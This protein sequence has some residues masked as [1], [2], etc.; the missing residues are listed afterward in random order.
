MRPVF[1]YPHATIVDCG[2]SRTSVAVFSRSRN[3]RLRLE[4]HATFAFSG[5]AGQEGNWL[6]HTS[7]ALVA[8][9]ARVN[10]VG[11][12]VVVLPPHLT[13]M[14][15]LSTPRVEK[16]KREKIISFEGQ[17]SIPYPLTD[18]VWD[19]MISGENPLGFNILLCA[20]KLEI[21][22]PLCAASATAGF[23]PSLLLPSVLALAAGYRGLQ[24]EQLWPTLLINVG[25]RS[26]AL[27]LLD[28]NGFQARSLS[29]GGGGANDADRSQATETL[30]NRL[31]HE[32]TRTLIYFGRPITP[33]NP[34]RLMLTGG[35]TQLPGLAGLVAKQLN[36]AVDPLNVLGGIEVGGKTE[37]FNRAENRS[38]VA[39]LIGGAVLQLGAGQPVFNLLPP[40][41]RAQAG[42]QRLRPRLAIA[43]ALAVMLLV[44][45]LVHER[46]LLATAH[47][48][49]VALDRELAPLRLTASRHQEHQ[50]RRTAAQRQQDAW[51]K[52]D[53]ARTGWLR[54]LGEMQNK[55]VQ[56]G[57]VWLE[58]MQLASAP[59]G[60]E[61]AKPANGQ[62]VRI[63]FAGLMRPKAGVESN[64]RDENYQRIRRLLESITEVSSVAAVEGERFEPAPAGQLRFEFVVVLKEPFAL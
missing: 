43:A 11:P 42:R 1:F 10:P 35:A 3:G 45:V 50:Q 30:A 61:P 40:R 21:L 31:A 34:L 58:R 4:R 27:V 5:E 18:V 29:L 54:F 44:P 37:D 46:Q 52:I 8:L 2:A 23:T 60:S 25:A 49:N 59:A 64:A 32:I 26:T 39:D 47:A 14:K 15:M 57:D 9:R 17:Q 20:A 28:K 48:Q 53:E 6:Q 56:T 51:Q 13:L 55:F 7:E 33:E 12:V 41:L 38:T 63:A 19:R 24:P 62:P 22:D 36:I 16:A